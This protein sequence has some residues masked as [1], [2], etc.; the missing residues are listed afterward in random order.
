MSTIIAKPIRFGEI[1]ETKGWAQK[2]AIDGLLACPECKQQKKWLYQLEPVE[3]CD[4]NVCSSCY[5]K[6][7]KREICFDDQMAELRS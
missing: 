2:G 4:G 6:K 5:D 7:K 3:S 1:K